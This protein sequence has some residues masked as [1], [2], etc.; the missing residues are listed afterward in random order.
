MNQQEYLELKRLLRILKR[1][2]QKLEQSRAEIQSLKSLRF[3]IL[4]VPFGLFINNLAH[5]VPVFDIKTILVSVV[6]IACVFAFGRI[7]D[8]LRNKHTKKDSSELIEDY[9]DLLQIIEQ[10]NY[11]VSRAAEHR[12]NRDNSDQD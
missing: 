8:Y 10:H 2:N 3:G 1:Q 4:L 11:P 6:S 5:S 9:N 7:I 12:S